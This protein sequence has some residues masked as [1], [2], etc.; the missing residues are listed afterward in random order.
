MK[1]CDQLPNGAWVATHEDLGK[2]AELQPRRPRSRSAGTIAQASA[3][4][5]HAPGEDLAPLEVRLR[6]G[7]Q[8]VVRPIREDEG[9][10][11]QN[12]IRRLSPASRYSRFFSG[13]RELPP[14]WIERATHPAD[15]REVQLV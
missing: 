6:D 3:I 9:E 14:K 10:K 11:L 2:L 15:G 1:G 8:V 7:R 12:A 13:L 4:M 5:I